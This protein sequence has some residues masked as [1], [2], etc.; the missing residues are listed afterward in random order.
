MNNP[1]RCVIDKNGYY[2]TLIIVETEEDENGAPTEVPRF[3]V[4]EKNEQ[5][6]EATPPD[7][8]KAWWNGS[9]WEE[10]AT[11]SEIEVMQKQR[12]EQSGLTWP[13]EPPEPTTEEIILDMVLDIT[14]QQ[15]MRE[16]G[17]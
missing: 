2:K 3:Y 8:T 6:I 10:K 16:L 9:D 5:L 13:P 4:L 7:M 17:I 15:S 12:Y 14:Y 11:P 1:H